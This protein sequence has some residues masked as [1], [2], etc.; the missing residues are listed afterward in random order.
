MVLSAHQTKSHLLSQVLGA[1]YH[2]ARID[3]FCFIFPSP[4][5]VTKPWAFIH[6]ALSGCD[7]LSS[8]PSFP[9]CLKTEFPFLQ[10]PAQKPSSGRLFLTYSEAVE[11]Y[12]FNKYLIRP[13]HVSKVWL[14]HK[15]GSSWYFHMLSV[16]LVT[17]SVT[18]K[19]Q[20][21]YGTSET[22]GEANISYYMI[23]N[24]K[25]MTKGAVEIWALRWPN[26]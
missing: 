11:I 4:L 15:A 16:S 3:L 8:L 7:S 23:L 21:H 24:F 5:Q 14:W 18:L 10:A 19:C 25:T 9:N 20:Y 2:L 22:P 13:C 17:F 26:S 1:L 6:M 12:T